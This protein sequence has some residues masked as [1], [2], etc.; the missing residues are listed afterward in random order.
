[1]L[2]D[3]KA[4]DAVVA[5]Y[6][7]SVPLLG[8]PST[9]SGG[10]GGGKAEGTAGCDVEAGLA[11]EEPALEGSSDSAASL[12][13]EAA[14]LVE[15]ERP[16]VPFVYQAGVLSVRMMRNWGRNPMMLAA[17][18]VQVGEWMPGFVRLPS[19]HARRR[20]LAEMDLV[21][22][23]QGLQLSCTSWP[24]RLPDTIA[25]ACRG[26]QPHAWRLSTA[27]WIACSH[28]KPFCP[29]ALPPQY[30]FLAIFVGLVYLR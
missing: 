12:A 10:K 18:G 21:A 20:K 30:L 15:A 23:R 13:S 1:M 3:G 29:P 25:G 5:A 6:A 8:S 28:A 16:C 2:R 26:A 22:G 19:A 17:E 11:G 27:R 14:A 24:A 7:A 4:A 9:S